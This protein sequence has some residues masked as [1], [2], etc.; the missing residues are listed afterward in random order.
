LFFYSILMAEEDGNHALV[1]VDG[2]TNSR[3]DIFDLNEDVMLPRED[4]WGMPSGNFKGK[5]GVEYFNLPETVGLLLNDFV[6]SFKEVKDILRI[7]PVARGATFGFIGVDKNLHPAEVESTSGEIKECVRSYFHKFDPEIVKAIDD[8]I[9]PGERYEQYGLPPSFEP[10]LIPGLGFYA[11]VIEDSKFLDSAL[12]LVLAPEIL[13]RL[14]SG[15]LSLPT[16]PEP[17]YLMCH[18]GLLDP[19]TGS[20]SDLAKKISDFSFDQTGYNLIGDLL[21]HGISRSWHFAGLVS[22]ENTGFGEGTIVLQGGHD[23]TIADIPAIAMYKRRKGNEE[24]IHFQAGSWGMAR[25]IGRPYTGLPSE[26][27]E[28]SVLLQ[29]TLDG[30]PVPTVL[31]PTGVE[32]D[33]NIGDKE[34]GRILKRLRLTPSD[35]KNSF[36]K[37][38]GVVRAKEIFVT[39]GGS[40]EGRGKGPFPKST[41]EIHGDYK[42]YTDETGE[43]AVAAVNLQT[44]IVTVA[45]IELISGKDSKCGVVLSGGGASNPL[46]RG[47]VASLMP[48][49][50]VYFISQKGEVQTETTSIGGFA[51]AKAHDLNIH[52]YKVDFGDNFGSLERVKP[53]DEIKGLPLTEYR[54]MFEQKCES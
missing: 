17:S 51:L 28:K 54:E 53:I 19:R 40:E 11:T 44:A 8:L 48:D 47:L 6:P 7:V 27:L 31:T 12:R 37:L 20:W 16:L 43:T 26:G 50:P 38:E 30:A 15:D 29:G 49:R 45:A 18:T 10:G 41:G 25:L 42:L 35:V 52:P 9:S 14:L 4:N 3:I 5:D 24:F 2:L 33:F 22:E 1:Y 23:S 34:P 13:A 39:P 46:Y 36:S 32:Y 21:S